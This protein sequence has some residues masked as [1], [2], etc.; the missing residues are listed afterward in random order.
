MRWTK[1]T[2]LVALIAIPCGGCESCLD[3]DDYELVDYQPFPG[4]GGT[5]SSSSSSSSGTGGGTTGPCPDTPIL[6]TLHVA[7][8]VEPGGSG[9]N[10]DPCSAP[11]S[12]N[13]GLD[14]Y[15]L[16]PEDGT[17]VAH[18][19]ITQES[20]ANLDS[21][22]RIHH[23]MGTTVVVAGTFRDGALALPDSCAGG[24]QV[25]L[26]EDGSAV[27]TLF[28]A[29]LN[30]DGMEFCTDW[31]GTAFTAANVMLQ[32]NAVEQ[33]NATGGVVIGGSLGGAT[34]HFDD[35][36]AGLD[37]TGEAFVAGYNPDGALGWV[38]EFLGSGDGAIMG[39][40]RLPSDWLVTG[41]NRRETP[42]CHSCTGTTHVG[43]A[44]ADCGG[45]GAGGTGGGGGA[46]GTGAGGGAGGSGGSS[47][48]GDAL[49]ALLWN[50][51]EGDVP[52]VAMDSYG[53][54]AAGSADAQVGY[55]VGVLSGASQCTT[56][57]TGLAG[58]AAWPFDVNAPNTALY[59][60]GGVKADAFVM[61]LDGSDGLTCGVDAEQAW[62]LR[63]TPSGGG[64]VAWGNRI[65]TNDCSDGATATILI[66][67]AASGTVALNR[68]LANGTCDAPPSNPALTDS[69]SQLLLVGLSPNGVLDWHGVVGPVAEATTSNAGGAPVGQ[70]SGN[71]ALD[72]AGNAYVAFETTG[73][74]ALQNWSPGGCTNLQ[75]G[76]PAGIYVTAFAQGG[77]DAAAACAW[78]HR[79][80]SAP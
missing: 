65:A 12:L 71:L 42:S 10:N 72:N 13:G 45:G 52:C 39:V 62:S 7:V 15:A 32:I 36:G 78:F 57:W 66:S 46:G 2:F 6:G 24:I 29:Q 18:G 5:A 35:G 26:I 20:G 60:A 56:Y 58:R 41:T 33:A 77:T 50:R 44:V 43:D 74:L 48:T 51:P 21:P 63:L 16:D 23:D 28:V 47:P 27:D 68:C 3:L 79:L 14:I 37:V 75:V 59:D 4:T 30:R 70:A 40:E 38:D 34:V 76:A 25:N 31:V 53:S 67:G 8:P 9:A 69:A 1:A 22:P 80:G 49:N 19:R 61:R 55:G 73:P 17:C 54:D 64:A 11:T